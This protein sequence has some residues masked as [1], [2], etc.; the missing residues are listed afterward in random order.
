MKKL[1]YTFYNLEDCRNYFPL[2]KQEDLIESHW[3]DAHNGEMDCQYY[4]FDAKILFVAMSATLTAQQIEEAVNQLGINCVVYLA[5]V[6]MGL[7]RR[8]SEIH[9]I[10]HLS[11]KQL[12]AAEIVQEASK[13]D[14]KYFYIEGEST[15]TLWANNIASG[16]VC[17]DYST[18]PHIKTFQGDWKKWS[19][20]NNAFKTGIC[21][22]Q[23]SRIKKF[24][25]DNTYELHLLWVKVF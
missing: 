9:Y 6:D 22:V 11:E 13:V 10:E 25:T 4:K 18:I 2:A 19:R 14:A 3:G 21:C 8:M 20:I 23:P 12:L 15:L 7:Q 16:L 5:E 24:I 17:Y 1:N